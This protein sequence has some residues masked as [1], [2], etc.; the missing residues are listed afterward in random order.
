MSTR[1]I[2][3]PTA[4]DVRHWA[5]E[6]NMAVSL[7]GRLPQDVVDAFNK[8]RTNKYITEQR[9]LVRTVTLTG[10]VADKAGRNRSRTETVE[11]PAVRAWAKDNGWPELG[12]NGRLPRAAFEA[13]ANRDAAP[14]KTKA[15]KAAKA[16]AA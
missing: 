4:D 8:R 16:K 6:R 13:Y 12:Y 9:I 10:K 5:I 14:V 7:K 3:P 2:V 1:T 11:V 15:R